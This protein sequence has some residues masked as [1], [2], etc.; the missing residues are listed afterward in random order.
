MTEQQGKEGR[1]KGK[2]A[3]KKELKGC[4]QSQMYGLQ[5]N[6]AS[7]KLFLFFRKKSMILFN[8]IKH[9]RTQRIKLTNTRKH[10]KNKSA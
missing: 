7:N 2:L 10:L 4:Y 6:P 8:K 9:F 1:R 3:L 5:F